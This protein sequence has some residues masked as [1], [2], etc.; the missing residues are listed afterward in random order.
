MVQLRLTHVNS[1]LNCHLLMVQLR[2]T[3]YLLMVKSPISFP[4]ESQDLHVI[5]AGAL[6]TLQA[7]PWLRR[8]RWGPCPAFGKTQVGTGYGHQNSRHPNLQQIQ[9]SN[10]SLPKN[11]CQKR[12][13]WHFRG[14][15]LYHTPPK[16]KKK[17]SASN[18]NSKALDGHIVPHPPLPGFEGGASQISRAAQVDELHV[19][20]AP[21][22]QDVPPTGQVEPGGGLDPWGSSW[23]WFLPIRMVMTWGWFMALGSLA[24]AQ[25][26]KIGIAATRMRSKQ[27]FLGGLGST[28]HNDDLTCWH[29]QEWEFAVTKWWFNQRIHGKLAYV[30]TNNIQQLYIYIYIY[31]CM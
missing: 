20:R 7:S 9:N 5:S 28:D 14:F 13:S 11:R 21:V 15:H 27:Q 31:V 26:R 16:K 4:F 1:Q 2:L 10:W 3:P 12:Q 29:K 30:R 25:L 17:T 8:K 18:K 24:L 22:Q 23:G 19:R 6:T